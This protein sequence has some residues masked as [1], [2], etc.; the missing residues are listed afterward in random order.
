[1][2]K[3]SVTP[4]AV[5]IYM[6]N[7][8]WQYNDL[9]KLMWEQESIPHGHV[10]KVKRTADGHALKVKIE[11]DSAQSCDNSCE[12]TSVIPAAVSIYFCNF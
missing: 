3:T 6:L 11:T 9:F 10:L 2:K 12:I 5:S 8:I 7:A 1:M 4:A